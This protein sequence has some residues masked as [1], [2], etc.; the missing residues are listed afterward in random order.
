[1]KQEV[2]TAFQKQIEKERDASIVYEAISYW[3]AAREYTGF[4][5]FFKKQS[6]EEYEHVEKL[7]EHLLI[8]GVQPVLGVLNAPPSHFENL[9][10]VAETALAHEQANTRGVLETLEVAK[11]SND[12]AA[13]NLLN[14]FVNEQVE[15]EAWAGRLVT[16]MSR[17]TSEGGIYNLD[18]H[19]V[20]DLTGK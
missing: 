11:A 4:A 15:E 13:L 3:C 6:K 9:A 14:W 12:Y 8:R 18:R 19:I 7:A 20:E 5:D 10:Q 1:M 17:I 2:I 16:L